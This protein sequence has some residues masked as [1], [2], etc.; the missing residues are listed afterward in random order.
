MAFSTILGFIETHALHQPDKPARV[1]LL[2]DERTVT[3]S[4]GDL[5]TRARGLAAHL[6]RSAASGDR[7]QA[8][9][10][11]VKVLE[12]GQLKPWTAE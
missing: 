3:L 10:G 2:G 8:V 1:F 12:D 11:Q 4:Y 6:K 5:V 7:L 9:E